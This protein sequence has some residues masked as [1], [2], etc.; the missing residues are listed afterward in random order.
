MGN[1][2]STLAESNLTGDIYT[3]LGFT[4]A[5]EI[6]EIYK[7]VYYLFNI[8]RDVEKFSTQLKSL[9][10]KNPMFGYLVRY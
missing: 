1:L 9:H 5:D 10:N 6:T 8:Q 2:S 4:F 7:T 3:C